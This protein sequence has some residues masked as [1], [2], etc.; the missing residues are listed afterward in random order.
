MFKLGKSYLLE[1]EKEENIEGQYE[2]G[3]ERG[4]IDEINNSCIISK[5]FKV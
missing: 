1:K 2:R 3:I 4:M 5:H